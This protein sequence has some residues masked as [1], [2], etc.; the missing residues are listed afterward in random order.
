LVFGVP[1]NIRGADLDVGIRVLIAPLPKKVTAF[2]TQNETT[3]GPFNAAL[4]MV[5]S[6]A[7]EGANT[8]RALKPALYI[9]FHIG[10]NMV[11]FGG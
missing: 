6:F 8:L 2:F 3:T 11:K 7:V 1:H 10:H 4:R 9:C 5:T